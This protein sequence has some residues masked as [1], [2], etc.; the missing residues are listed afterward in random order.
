MEGAGNGI[1]KS[2][3]FEVVGVE[4][5]VDSKIELVDGNYKDGINY[6]KDMGMTYN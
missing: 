6:R 5:S 1:T 3:T 2:Y 4:R